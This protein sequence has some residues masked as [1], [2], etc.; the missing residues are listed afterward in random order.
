VDILLY[1]CGHRSWLAHHHAQAPESVGHELAPPEHECCT[2]DACELLTGTDEPCSDHLAIYHCAVLPLKTFHGGVTDLVTAGRSC[3]MPGVMRYPDGG[4][5]TAEKRLVA[6]RCGSARQRIFRTLHQLRQKFT[7]ADV[8]KF[9]HS[10]AQLPH[11]VSRG[12][13]KNFREF[14]IKLGEKTPTVDTAY[15]QRLIAKAILFRTTERIVSARQFGGYRANIVTYTIARLAHETAQRIDL[16]RI[17]REQRLSPALAAAIDDLCVL[18]YDNVTEWA[19]RRARHHERQAGRNCKIPPDAAFTLRSVAARLEGLGKST[20]TGP[21]G[22]LQQRAKAGPEP[23]IRSFA[24]AFDP[25][26]VWATCPSPTS[27]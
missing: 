12:A 1:G 11:I 19:K 25:R 7:K 4:G 18:V 22:R 9:E 10:W 27:S 5:L 6:R 20:L 24:S 15:S 8:A 14:M 16:D 2:N 23:R 13:E 3:H 26:R 17:W 21:V